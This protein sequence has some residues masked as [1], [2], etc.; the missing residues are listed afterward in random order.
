MEGKSIPKIIHFCWYGENEFPEIVKKCIESWKLMLPDWKII[1]WNEKNSPVNSKHPYLCKALEKKQFAFAADYT[2]CYALYEYGGVYLDTDVEV[3]RDFE[4]LRVLSGFL[5]PE[6]CAGNLYNVAVFGATKS[7]IFCHDMMYYYNE[8]SHFEPI[9]DIVSK[10]L[11]KNEYDIS[12][13]NRKSFYPYNPFDNAQMV[14]QL[15]FCDLSNDTYAIHHWLGSWKPT[16]IARVKNRI[17]HMI[18]K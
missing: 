17:K 15:L 10:L 13:L 14:K 18:N 7:H 5:A 1:L 6:N 9:P 11:K 16:F 2:R 8:L 4:P 3:I 12:I